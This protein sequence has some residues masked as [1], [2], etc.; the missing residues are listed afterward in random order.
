M[1]STIWDSHADK[2]QPL[3]DMLGVWTPNLRSM[4]LDVVAK[5][6]GKVLILEDIIASQTPGFR[7]HLAWWRVCSPRI[8]QIHSLS[9]QS[10]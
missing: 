5:K 3:F 9:K 4:S 1:V 2:E 10:L 8:L 7:A 6:A